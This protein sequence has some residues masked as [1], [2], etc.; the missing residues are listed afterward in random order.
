MA[1]FMTALPGGTHKNQA[2]QFLVRI[3]IMHGLL[4]TCCDRGEEACC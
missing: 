4:A 1:D 2:S 3:Q